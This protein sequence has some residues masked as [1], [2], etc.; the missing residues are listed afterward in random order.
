[1][2][3]PWRFEYVDASYELEPENSTEEALCTKHYGESFEYLAKV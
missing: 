1:M 2:S 3:V